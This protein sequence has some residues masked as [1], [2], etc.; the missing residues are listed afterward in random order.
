MPTWTRWQPLRARNILLDNMNNGATLVNYFGHSSPTTWTYS[1][2]FAIND[3]PN[4][5]NLGA[6]FVVAQYGCWNTYFVNPRQDS[7]GQQFL[8]AQDRG[9]VAVLG[10]TT[11]NYLHSQNYLG[12]YLT[13]N[14]A[15]PGMTIGQALL[16]AK[17]TMAAVMPAYLEIELGWTIFGDPTLM[18]EP[19][20]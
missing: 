13:P 15:T 20:P 19:S 10:S 7:L 11:N 2:L 18:V 3:I 14:L 5:N 1:G 8:F 12:Q 6:P 4:L 9:A 16:S 17:Q